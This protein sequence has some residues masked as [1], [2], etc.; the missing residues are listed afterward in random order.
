ME[1]RKN[2]SFTEAANPITARLDRADPGEMVQLFSRCDRELFHGPEG[3]PPGGILHEET[4]EGLV[5]AARL[6]RSSLP[7]R[8]VLS[9]AGT[10]GRLAFLLARAFGPGLRALGGE[11]V[12]L[13]AGG[14][15]SLVKAVE[16][17]EDDV[18]E[19][20]R[21][22]REALGQE[23]KALFIGITCGLSAPCVGGGLL[24]AFARE[25][26]AVILLGTNRPERAR[27][28][29]LGEG[30]PTLKDLVLQA[31]SREKACVLAPRVG[32]EA[33]TGST[34]LKCGSATW[35]LLAALF[36]RVLEGT[37]EGEL[38]EAFRR[39]LEEADRVREEVYGKKE[40]LA[41]LLAG[42]G[43]ALRGGD[44]ILYAGRGDP[45]LAGLL[46]ASE[47][48]PTFGA[49]DDDVRAF[50]EGGWEVLLG[51][52]ER[53]RRLEEAWPV[54][55]DFCRRHY[56]GRLGKKSLVLL[57]GAPGGVGEEAR[58]KGLSVE[59][60]D[61]PGFFR[62]KLFLNLLS[63]GAHVLAGKVY[64]NRMVDVRIS[65]SKLFERALRIVEDISGAGRE[66]ALEAL[67]GAVHGMDRPPGEL[68]E[69]PPEAHVRAAAGRERVVPLAVLVAA[70]DLPLARAR[71]LLE[72][73][74]ILRDALERARP[75]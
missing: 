58:A 46:D 26:T 14:D 64:G 35:L 71:A 65:N 38:R 39:D 37:P 13:I 10:S 31:A 4:L 56:L 8:V 45:G 75:S 73:E 1:G 44:T 34:R 72:K 20:R 25:D 67:V 3:G 74:P 18:E 54:D 66:K 30:N 60:W 29:S 48:P 62:A 24:E 47:C 40:F 27:E 42:G 5:S 43:E 57:L 69:A 52:G 12:P 33:V 21:R 70:R 2:L 7:G 15:L 68:L 22:A 51:R 9:G 32:A 50:L 23:G 53:A 19:A 36:R 59:R 55:L 11:T 6:L 41:S 28:V 17:A 16:E 63:T 49:R 61:E